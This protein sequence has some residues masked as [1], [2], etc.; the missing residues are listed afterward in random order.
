V[1]N[2]EIYNYI[3]LKAE[4]KAHYTFKTDSDTEVCGCIYNLWKSMLK[5]LTECFLLHLGNQDKN[6]LLQEIDLGQT[7]F[8]SKK[9]TLYFFIGNKSD[10]CCWKIS[11]FK[12]ESMGFCP[13]VLMEILM[14]LL[15]R[16]AQLPGRAFFRISRISS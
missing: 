9:T 5:K 4:L 11:R 1:F 16:I 8:Y 14:K 12:R 10:T 6:Y 3:E 15:G 7:L 2:G 13:M